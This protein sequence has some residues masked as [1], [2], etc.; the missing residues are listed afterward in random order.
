[1]GMKTNVTSLKSEHNTL[2]PATK[3]AQHAMTGQEEVW[4][5]IPRFTEYFF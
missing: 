5:R 1:M 4:G 3:I 2:I